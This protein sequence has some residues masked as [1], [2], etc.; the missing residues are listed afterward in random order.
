MM[1]TIEINQNHAMLNFAIF[2]ITLLKVVKFVKMDFNYTK[3]FHVLKKEIVK[4]IS[5]MIQ[6]NRNAYPCVLLVQ[7]II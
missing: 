7:I 1:K 5:F 3:I 6:C 2:A 4:I